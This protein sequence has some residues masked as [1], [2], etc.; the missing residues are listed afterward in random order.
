M[1]FLFPYLVG[2]AVAYILFVKKPKPCAACDTMPV[3]DATAKACGVPD[4]IVC[5][6]VRLVVQYKDRGAL[7]KLQEMANSGLLTNE[8]LLACRKSIGPVGG[9]LK[10]S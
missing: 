10:F 3:D 2:G 9:G 7:E 6:L 1:P 4:D 8:Q 5:F